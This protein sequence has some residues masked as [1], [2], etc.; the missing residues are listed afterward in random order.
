MDSAWLKTVTFTRSQLAEL[1]GVSDGVLSFWLKNG[2]LKP[3]EAGLGRGSHRRFSAY[4]VTIAAILGS[5]QCYALKL[6]SLKSLAALLYSAVDICSSSHMSPWSLDAA[7]K[8]ARDIHRFRSGEDF[9]CYIYHYSEDMASFDY[10][11]QKVESECDL[12]SDLAHN[13]SDYDPTAQIISFAQNL[14]P[15]D[16]RLTQIFLQ[17]ANEM[18]GT[19]TGDYGWLLWQDSRNSWRVSSQTEPNEDFVDFPESETAIFM[20]VG[21]IIRRVWNIDL[22]AKREA[23]AYRTQVA[24]DRFAGAKSNAD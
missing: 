2:V 20:A 22:E 18:F 17:I 1:S 12:Y 16:Y 13:Y 6:T 9:E 11:K 10:S 8:L 21:K 14:G 19:D 15:D 23:R 3:V 7:G 5:L 4:T 24:R